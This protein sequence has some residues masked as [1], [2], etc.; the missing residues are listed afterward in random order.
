MTLRR[1]VN[2]TSCLPSRRHLVNAKRVFDL[3]LLRDELCLSLRI[4]YV[5]FRHQK[6]PD[7]RTANV[8]ECPPVDVSVS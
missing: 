2:M 3:R 1:E 7:A 4:Q 5:G 6:M 8:I